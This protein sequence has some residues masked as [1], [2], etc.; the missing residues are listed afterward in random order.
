MEYLLKASGIVLLLFLFY[1]VFLKNETFFK[2]IRS[3]FIVGLLIVLTIPLI[4][5]PIYVEA[6]ASQLN[7]LDYK[8]IISSNSFEQ[9]IDWSQIIL[10][11]YLIGVTFFSIKFLVQL[12]S[13]GN[14]VSKHQ[15]TKQG[16]YYFVETSKTI[17]PFSFF[18]IIIYN[19]SQFTIDELEHIINHEKAHAQQWHSID[20]ILAHLL[21]ITL[22]FNP[23]VWLYKKAVQQNLEFLADA[24]A[25]ELANNHKLYQF[26]LLKTCDATYCT[27]LT[28]N[29]YNSLI[30][31]RILMLHKNRSQNKSQWKY[32]L[33]LPV[34]IAFVLTFNTKVI[35]QEKKLTEIEEV[36]N[37]KVDLVIDKNSTDEILN[38]ETETFKKEFDITLSFKGIKRN[39]DNEITAIK[40]NA[41]GKN[42]KA[43]FE[44]AGS[45]PIK[46]I[47]ITYNSDNNSLSI[48]NLSKLHKNHYTYRVHE[49]GDVEFKGKPDKEGNFVFITSEGKEKKWKQ[50]GNKSEN[51]FVKKIVVEGDKDNYWIHKNDDNNHVKVEVTEINEGEHEVKVIEE[52]HEIGAEGEHV[53]EIIKEK[54]D[55]NVFILKKGADKDKEFNISK[56]TVDAVYIEDENRKSLI[57]I[58]GKESTSNDLKNLEPN[59]VSEINVLKGKVAIEKYGEKATN[60]VILI[61]TKKN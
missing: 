6:V 2:S 34:L 52:I 54:S 5:V 61:T 51:V 18:N 20:T 10:L 33:L 26:T 4:E 44:N 35:A 59:S 13:L 30:K 9:S 11:I 43:K 46:P 7:L 32:A 37:V 36:D 41:K 58:D 21:V 8:E 16:S 38:G 24:Y 56:I 53:I 49:S 19:K 50:K 42:L 57:F 25:L 23:F 15:L 31:K 28:N 1:I 27:A 48:S 17:S 40:I 60:G 29:F 45:E 22:W 14:L 47:K 55:E 12:I 39:A 3:F